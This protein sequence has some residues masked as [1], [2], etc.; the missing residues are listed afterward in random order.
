MAISSSGMFSNTIRTQP[1]SEVLRDSE[2][3]AQKAMI[4]DPGCRAAFWSHLYGSAPPCP[5][6]PI[7]NSRTFSNLSSW[8]PHPHGTAHHPGLGLWGPALRLANIQTEKPIHNWQKLVPEFKPRIAWA[9]GAWGSRGRPCTVFEWLE[10][11]GL[12][13]TILPPS[14]EE[15]I[16]QLCK[17]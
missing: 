15:I 4:T 1:D 3:S 7:T 9:T 13:E 12:T 8:F 6:G 14:N 11:Q 5:P 2:P 16:Q 17:H 10:P